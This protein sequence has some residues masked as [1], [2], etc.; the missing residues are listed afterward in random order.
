M[1]DALL[2]ILAPA[3]IIALFLVIILARQ[4]ARGGAL[5]LTDAPALRS[6]FTFDFGRELSAV[7]LLE[8]LAAAGLPLSSP[9]EER[10]YARAEVR[11]P[12]GFVVTLSDYGEGFMGAVARAPLGVE[13]PKDDADAR[14]L[15]AKVHQ[16]LGACRGVE[17]VRWH[18]YQALSK[19]N[20]ETAAAAPIEPA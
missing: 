2:S 8:E 14:A 5:P 6:L 18:K 19:G 12:A 3:L 13:P 10:G 16:T 20:A 1:A 17:N 11:E 7:E 9:L 15:L 4:L